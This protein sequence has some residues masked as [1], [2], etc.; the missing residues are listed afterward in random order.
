MNSKS[1][2]RQRL[3]LALAALLAALAG[4][5]VGAADEQGGERADAARAESPATRA[6]READRFARARRVA[7][8][9][10]MNRLAGQRLISGVPGTRIPKGLR[11]MIR[12][13]EVAGVIL[14][15]DNFPSRAAGRRL[16]RRL[17]AIPR[18]PRLAD[19]LLVMIDQEGGQV[20]RINGAPTVSAAEMGR[21][22]RAFSRAQGRRTGRNLGNVGV[23]VNLAP[24]LDVGRPGGDI[25]KT[26]RA[27]GNTVAA[28]R[29]T[30]IPFTQG[31]R[32]TGVAATAKHFPGLGAV[33]INTDFA[34]QTISLSKRALRT[35]DEAPYRDFI[36]AGGELVML[37]TAIYPAFA[38]R[39]AAFTRAIATTE[40]RQ[41]LGF[42]GVT[43]TDAMGTVAVNDY[44]GSPDRAA[45]AAVRAGV[46]LLL[47][48]DYPSARRAASVLRRRLAGGRLPRAEFT[49]AAARVLAL[50]AALAP[51]P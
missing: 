12:R 42:K 33:R 15:A 6:D 1:I 44:Y 10:P 11:T 17:Q 25:A 28:V 32:S 46:D 43:V 9:L 22:G 30:A 14:F 40:L 24:V 37:S 29:A 20:K 36:A 27:F 45:L 47:Y 8:G 23:N 35:I 4:V 39:P 31:M 26:D 51:R 34:A 50:R 16:I 7:A 48:T 19:P 3:A 18:P 13:G 5:A 49:D 21:R 2:R 38:N 41:R